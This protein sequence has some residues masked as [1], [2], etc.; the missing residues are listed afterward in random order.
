[1]QKQKP[2]Y[3]LNT[4]LLHIP[5]LNNSYENCAHSPQYNVVTFP[6]DLQ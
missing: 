3:I 4:L 5:G 1:M 6:A 2:G